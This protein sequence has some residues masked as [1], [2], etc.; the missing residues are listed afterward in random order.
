MLIETSHYISVKEWFILIK[1]FSVV[2]ERSIYKCKVYKIIQVEIMFLH[3]YC[4]LVVLGGIKYKLG[5]SK[6]GHIEPKQFLACITGY[7]F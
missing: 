7:V 6:R 1:L 3:F 4:L 5:R 2:I